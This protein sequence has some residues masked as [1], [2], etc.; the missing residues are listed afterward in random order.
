MTPTDFVTLYDYNYWAT[1]KILER[2]A[3][4]TPEQYAAPASVPFGSLR[5]TLVHMLSAE[6]N[7]RRRCE[8]RFSPS[9]ML[10]E[11]DYPAFDDVVALWKEEEA[12]MRGY[13]ASLSEADL[14]ERI[15]YRD[16]RGNPFDVP[17][18]LILT[19]VVNHGTQHRSE[20]GIMLTDFGHSPGNIDFIYYVLDNKL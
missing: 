16:S 4:L 12:A 19:H 5:G 13:V 7:W 18:H 1:R 20:C 14:A 17:L 3:E 2:A 15:H 8:E 9:Q 6:R 10:A 11:A